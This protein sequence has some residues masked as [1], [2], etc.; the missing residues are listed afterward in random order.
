M[1]IDGE[2]VSVGTFEEE[3]CE[4]SISIR[5]KNVKRSFRRFGFHVVRTSRIRVERV[6]H[7]PFRIVLSHGSQLAHL[8]DRFLR[9]I[10]L[11][12]GDESEKVRS[13][14]V[15]GTKSVTRSAKWCLITPCLVSC[16]YDAL[17]TREIRT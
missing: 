5:A 1:R 8:R 10:P 14:K 15:A 13:P 16:N 12:G 4:G 11:T 7:A 3:S 9:C 17:C 6:F 2:G